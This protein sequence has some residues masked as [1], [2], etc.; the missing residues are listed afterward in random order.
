[1]ARVIKH[2]Y[3]GLTQLHSFFWHAPAS[4]SPDLLLLP[5]VINFQDKLCKGVCLCLLHPPLEAPVNYIAFAVSESTGSFQ[6]ARMGEWFVS[7]AF[8]KCPRRS[9]K[10]GIN[11]SNYKKKKK[12]QSEKSNRRRCAVNIRDEPTV[13]FHGMFNL[14]INSKLILINSE[15]T[16]LMEELQILTRTQCSNEEICYLL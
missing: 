16:V 4:Q 2:H 3:I 12:L 13:L 1:M 10:R 11:S 8:T 14:Q 6:H 9:K 7:K 5:H 15:K